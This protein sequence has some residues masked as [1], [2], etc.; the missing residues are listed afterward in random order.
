MDINTCFETTNYYH[1]IALYSHLVPTALALFLSIYALIKTHFS[2]LSIIF[3]LFTSA[4]SLW[5]IGDV[6]IWTTKNYFYVYALWSWLDYVNI[7]FFVLGAYFFGILARVKISLVE[8]I[9][10]VLICA[11]AFYQEACSVQDN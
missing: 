6:I 7:V 11:L 3:F 5:L 4:F 9:I 1:T 8:K 10:Y 2:K